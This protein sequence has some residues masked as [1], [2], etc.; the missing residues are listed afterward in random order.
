MLSFLQTILYFAFLFLL[1][2][3]MQWYV[4]RAF[5]RWVNRSVEES[6]QKSWRSIGFILLIAANIIF[7]LRFLLT[8]LGYYENFF[9]QALIIY[10]GGVFFAGVTFAFAAVLIGDGIRYSVKGAKYVINKYRKSTPAASVGTGFDPGRRK[11][12]KVAGTAA[13]ASPFIVTMTS[14]AATSRDYQIVRPELFFPDLPTALDGFKI[15]QISDLHSGIYM[16]Q[17]QI[18]EIFEISNSLNPQLV[19]LTGDLVDTSVTEIPAIYNTLPLVKSDYGV[20]SCL[21]N[22]DHYAS[23]TAVTAAVQQRDIKMLNNSHHTLN[24]D[25]DPLDIVGVDDAGSGS[26]NFARIDQALEGTDPDHFKVML[27]HRPDLFNFKGIEN[28][29]LTLAGH[30]HG[31]QIGGRF[32]GIPVYPVQLFHEYSKGLFKR[33]N[34][35]L[36]VN[37]GVGMVG[38]PIRIVRPEITEITLRKGSPEQDVPGV[39]G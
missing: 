22:H 37:V 19:A 9:V 33:E 18:Q 13:V 31:G 24:I 23:G 12:L 36:Y 27:S 11:F 2:A 1:F 4:G 32:L 20:Y 25:G 26:R 16:T 21:G 8:E 39:G 34:Q 5:V 6:K 10:P 28:V 35:K 3:A 29:N 15:V 14:S 38:V 7:S 30:T 17:R